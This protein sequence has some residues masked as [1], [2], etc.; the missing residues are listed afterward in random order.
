MSEIKP[1]LTPEG[2]AEA[3]RCGLPFVSDG[4]S[5]AVGLTDDDGDSLHATAALALHGQPFGFTWE[6]VD[7]L[8]LELAEEW[9]GDT[10]EAFP[11]VA[12][13]RSLADRIAALLPRRAQPTP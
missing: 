7:A 11:H 10:G 13:L 9:S 1:A 3:D 4:A 8:H 2:W 6:D 5:V 12:R